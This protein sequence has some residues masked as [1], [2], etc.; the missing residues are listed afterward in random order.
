[1]PFISTL[2]TKRSNSLFVLGTELED[3]KSVHFQDVV[4]VGKNRYGEEQVVHMKGA[5]NP[6]N[7]GGNTHKRKRRRR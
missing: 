5:V 1:M 3:M 7:K 4:V 6:D 2:H